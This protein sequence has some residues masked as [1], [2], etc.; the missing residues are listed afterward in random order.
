[1]KSLALA[2][3]TLTFTLDGGILAADCP[4]SEAF[5]TGTKRPF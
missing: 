2:L 1:M 3:L 4:I 5:E